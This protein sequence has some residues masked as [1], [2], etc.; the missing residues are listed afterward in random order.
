[1]LIW[2]L[3]LSLWKISFKMT[4]ICEAAVNLKKSF[5][6]F[7][8]AKRKWSVNSL[9]VLINKL[10][11]HVQRWL[12]D[13]QHSTFWKRVCSNIRFTIN[14]PVMTACQSS[15]TA[16]GIRSKGTLLNAFLLCTWMDNRIVLRLMVQLWFLLIFLPRF[17]LVTM[18]LPVSQPQHQLMKQ[19]IPA[20]HSASLWHNGYL[21]VEHVAEH[22]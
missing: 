2:K 11:K 19:R 7:N 16:D 5:D 9:D 18:Y 21:D 17:N 13:F 6:V 4:N 22:I 20:E 8:F 10:N 1:M 15:I 14:R 3:V 12:A